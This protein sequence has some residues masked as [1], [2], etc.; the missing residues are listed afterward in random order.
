MLG[1]E[2]D[3]ARNV[4]IA[5]VIG[6]VVLAFVSASIVKN[7]T[8]KVVTIVLMLGVAGLVWSQRSGLQDCADRVRASAADGQDADT[9]CRLLWMEITVPD[10]PDSPA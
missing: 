1:L 2:V 6:L 10:V 5:I 7:I 9:T 3:Q 4:G 8:V